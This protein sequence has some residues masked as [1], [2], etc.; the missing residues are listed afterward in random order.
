MSEAVLNT[1]T[2]PLPIRERFSTKKITIRNHKNGILL[3]PFRD[4]GA[5]RGIAKGSSFTTEALASYRN[6][7]RSME[8]NEAT[9]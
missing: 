7:D 3:L 1:N 6:D 2:L 8:N 5:H 9:V 4:I